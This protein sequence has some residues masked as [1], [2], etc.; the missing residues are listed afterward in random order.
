MVGI[1]AALRLSPSHTTRRAGPHR[2]VQIFRSEHSQI[3]NRLA[4]S[5]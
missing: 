5:S 1:G 4:S 3:I 2:A